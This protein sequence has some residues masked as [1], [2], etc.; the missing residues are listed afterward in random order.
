MNDF[1]A[2]LNEFETLVL[3][4]NDPQAGRRGMLPVQKRLNEVREKLQS[5]ALSEMVT[6]PILPEEHYKLGEA[7]VEWNRGRHSLG[8]NPITIGQ[9]YAVAQA[10]LCSLKGIS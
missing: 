3:D 10:V 6:P 9:E 1:V 7:L 4:L 5:F 2:L 8:N